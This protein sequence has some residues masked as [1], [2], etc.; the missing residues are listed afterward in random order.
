MGNSQYSLETTLENAK[1]LVDYLE[2]YKNNFLIRVPESFLEKQLVHDLAN[3]DKQKEII[4]RV[5]ENHD[6]LNK[7]TQ[8]PYGTVVDCEV[9]AVKD[10]GIFVEFGVDAVGFIH[11]S[12]FNYTDYQL[13]DIE[14]GDLLNA[15]VKRYNSE[16]HKYELEFIDAIANSN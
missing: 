16:H 7:Q 11:I 15:K 2:K 4:Q 10:Y 3:L 12:E 9:V 14:A 6:F 13:E 1:E 5:I 8:Y